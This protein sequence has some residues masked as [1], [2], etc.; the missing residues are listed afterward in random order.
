MNWLKPLLFFG[1]GVYVTLFFSFKSSEGK[2]QGL[3]SNKEFEYA[4]LYV[5]EL[6][7]IQRNIYFSNGDSEKMEVVNLKWRENDPKYIS[8]AFNYLNQKGYELKSSSAYH[9]T[10]GNDI[11]R[12]IIKEYIFIRE[13]N[14]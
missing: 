4:F 5:Y 2:Q 1:M 10:T 11:T 12:E 3:N 7:S 14:N 9:A 6:N 13:K 8:E